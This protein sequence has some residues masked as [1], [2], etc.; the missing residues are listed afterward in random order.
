MQ[1]I[2][3]ESCRTERWIRGREV[4]TGSLTNPVLPGFDNDSAVD[5]D[6]FD[7]DDAAVAAHEPTEHALHGDTGIP[8]SP[9]PLGAVTD[10]VKRLCHP[11]A[12]PYPH[13][14]AHLKFFAELS[15]TKDHKAANPRP[16][17]EMPY[18]KNDRDASNWD[19]DFIWGSFTDYH[20]Q[21]W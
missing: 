3:A 16:D 12:T 20:T 13:G 21:G 17:P 6:W 19:G 2:P 15:Y 10:V 18:M 11:Q 7:S 14:V 4:S 8:A 1:N 5:D 9:P